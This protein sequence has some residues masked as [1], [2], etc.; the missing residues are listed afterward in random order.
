VRRQ[1]RKVSHLRNERVLLPRASKLT[2]KLAWSTEGI[3]L[4][5]KC[6]IDAGS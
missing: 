6:P 2:T 4:I 1:Q 3:G 5:L